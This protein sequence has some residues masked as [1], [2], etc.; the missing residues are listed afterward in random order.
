MAIAG[1]AFAGWLALSALS[2]SA[3]ASAAQR[4]THPDSTIRT[5]FWEHDLRDVPGRVREI[6]DR[7]LR[8]AGSWEGDLRDVPDRV[9]EIGD[10]PVRFLQ[11][12]RHDVF[13]RKDRTVRQVRE[14]ADAAG[15]PRVRLPRVRQDA[16][17]VEG[18]V[19]DI[20]G[21]RPVLDK[22]LL[23]DA[24]EQPAAE[25]EAQAGNEAQAD[26]EA[27]APGSGT[28]A[29]SG[30][31]PPT[32]DAF[33]GDRKPGHCRGCQGNGHLPGPVLPSGQDNPRSGGNGGHPFSPVADLRGGRYPAAPSAVE[34][35][36]FH[37]TALTDLSAPGGPSVVPD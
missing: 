1:F 20:A 30:H 34:S 23:P 33:A 10:H 37:R 2:E 29:R 25:D 36:T 32:P 31:S 6:G 5:G 35:G 21:S 22:G 3:S 8:H 28:A 27:A 7:P 16:P 12:R 14:L 26:D 13:E 11:A 17:L 15:V 9:Q 24:G 19:H 18:L 4:P